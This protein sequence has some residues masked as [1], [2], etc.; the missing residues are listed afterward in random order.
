M[1]AD[2][3]EFTRLSSTLSPSELVS[4][5]N[6]VFTVF[7]GL[8]ERYGLEKVKTIGDAYMVVGG[9]TDEAR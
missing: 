7:D 9:M 5:L 8:V 4:V 3:V 1:F 6:E 2:I